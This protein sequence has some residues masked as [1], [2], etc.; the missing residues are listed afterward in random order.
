MYKKNIEVFYKINHVPRTIQVNALN[1]TKSQIRHGKKYIML[2][3][4]TG[5]GKS[6]YSIMFINWYLNYINANA[7]F[8]ILTNSKILQNQYTEEF[9]YIASL[10]GKNSYSC[11]SYPN[12]SCQ[13][14]KELN[15]AMKKTCTNC[16]YDKAMFGWKFN[17]ISLTNFHLFDTLNLFLPTLVDE[18]KSSVLIID[19]AHDFENVLCDFISNK[20]S[21]KSLKSLGFT[22]FNIYSIYADIKN[23]KTIDEYADYVNNK[24]LDKIQKLQQTVEENVGGMNYSIKE[25]V[26]LSKNLIAINSAI[27]NYKTFLKDYDE[28]KNNWVLD[29]EK[30]EDAAFKMNLSAQPV[31]SHKY[32]E[33]LIW[34][35]YDHIIFMSGTLLDKDLFSYLNGIDSSLSGYYDIESPFPIQNRPIYYAKNVGKMSFTDKEKTFQNQINYIDN[36]INKH[37]NDKGIIHCSNYELSNWLEKHYKNNKRFIFHTTDNRDEALFKHIASK[38]PTIIVSPSMISGVDFKDDLSRFQIIT[39]IPYPNM[40]STKIKKRM[41]DNK[42]W[43][44]YKTCCDFIQAYGRSIRNMND[45]C[46]TYVLDSSFSLLLRYGYKYFPEYITNAIKI[47]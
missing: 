13:E 38:E 39:K 45:H 28:N 14:G 30:T 43:Y 4:P 12:T 36:I 29:F 9:P 8:D 18:R 10:K 20:I 41:L 47:F 40:G 35:R 27:N 5:T 46:D 26:K 15:K 34:N 22:D 21:K 11:D 16:P 23:I 19:E 7:K 24:L 25:K 2:N 31:W 3:M 32:L 44:Q 42:D 1:F 33:K 37:K 17:Q 6:L